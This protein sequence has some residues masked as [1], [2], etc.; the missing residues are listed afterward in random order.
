LSAEP[1]LE[2]EDLSVRFETDEGRV[3]AVDEMSEASP[4]AERA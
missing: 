3:Q 1:L 4:A 2:V